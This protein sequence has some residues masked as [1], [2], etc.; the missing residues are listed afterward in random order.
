MALPVK[1]NTDAHGQ[2]YGEG[3]HY[4]LAETLLGA[5]AAAL[6][7]PAVSSA[8]TPPC[9]I[10]V[11]SVSRTSTGIYVVTLA[12]CYYAVAYCA[13][14]VDDGASGNVDARI[15]NW[16]NLQTS[17]PATFTI[18]TYVPGGTTPVDVA[19]AVAIR[20]F[21]VFKKDPTGAAA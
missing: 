14:E 2:W 12:D 11:V 1:N 9:A 15:S 4:I 20:I 16:T 17:T 18:R 7:V 19:A 5:G 8:T 3:P 10:E 21:V 6:T 13:A